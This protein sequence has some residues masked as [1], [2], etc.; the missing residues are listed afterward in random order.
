MSRKEELKQEAAAWRRMAEWVL[1]GAYFRRAYLCHLLDTTGRYTNFDWYDSPP[2]HW[3]IA[4]MSA[5]VEEHASVEEHAIAGYGTLDVNEW[6]QSN[7]VRAV[8]CDLMALEC[9]A[10]AKEVPPREH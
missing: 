6:P 7:F 1:D 2:R 5:R 4:A 3:P 9:E 10:E 8:F